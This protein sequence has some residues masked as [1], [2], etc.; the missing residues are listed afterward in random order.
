MC[1]RNKIDAITFAQH[2]RDQI[3]VHVIEIRQR[4]KAVATENFQSTPRISRAI[5]QQAL[6]N[7]IREARRH[8]LFPAVLTFAPLARHHRECDIVATRPQSSDECGNVGGIILAVAIQRHHDIGT[9]G[10]HA[11]A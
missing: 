8:A 3:A 5:I 7:A 4:E 9:C 2:Q 1:H 6:A 10:A 11:G